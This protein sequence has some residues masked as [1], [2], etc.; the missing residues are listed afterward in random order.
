MGTQGLSKVDWTTEWFC[1]MSDGM[2]CA[3][4][5]VQ[6]YLGVELELDHVSSVCLYVVGEECQRPIWPADLNGVCDKATGC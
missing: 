3:A 2:P 4:M 1:S 5:A 6:A